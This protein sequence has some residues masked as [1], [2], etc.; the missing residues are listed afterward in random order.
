[1]LTNL[2]SLTVKETAAGEEAPGRVRKARRSGHAEIVVPVL[3]PP[4][5]GQRLYAPVRR[6]LD[7]AVAVG[8]LVVFGPVI[9]LAAAV[10]RLTSRGPAFYSQVRTGKD[11][12][13]FTLY[14]LRTMVHNCESLTGPRWTIPGD[15]RVTR[16]GWLLRRTHLDELPQLLNIL[17]GEMSLIG[18]RPE[19]PEFI[20][21]LEQV[22]P[23]YHGRHTVLPGITG[24]AQV[25]LDPDT[26]VESV[27]QKLQY[28][29]YF[30]RH[31]SPLLDARVL[32]ATGL[33]VVGVSFARLSALRVVPSFDHVATDVRELTETDAPRRLH[34]QAA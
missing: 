16:V 5:R 32:L 27:R 18:P 6:A 24:L 26:D 13:P 10:I 15:P 21:E 2:D 3:P 28:D 23:G 14:K 11:G 9:L 12:R 20:A 19:R 31:A 33:H 1:M 8:L 22:I 25:Q 29:L 7:V 30:V 4:T 34:K 17:K